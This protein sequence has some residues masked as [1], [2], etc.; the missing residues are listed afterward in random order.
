MLDCWAEIPEKLRNKKKEITV[1]KKK[2]ILLVI[3]I[4]QVQVKFKTDFF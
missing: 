4:K 3:I 2:V 1:R